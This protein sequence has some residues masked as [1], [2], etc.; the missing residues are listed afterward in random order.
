M[1]TIRILVVDDCDQDREFLS[2]VARSSAGPHAS[3]DTAATF[4]K[5]VSAVAR[6]AYDL[7]LL[8]DDLGKGTNA[9]ISVVT[10]RAAGHVSNIIVT[11]GELREKRRDE[12]SRAGVSEY[13]V[14]TEL[15][16]DIVGRALAA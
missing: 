13:H 6:A 2:G 10:L 7:I 4:E 11:G 8:D 16:A 9:F 3:I 14:K 12:L 1:R 15:T 5:A